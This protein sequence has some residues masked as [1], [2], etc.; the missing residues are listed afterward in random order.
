[1]VDV[2]IQAAI[3]EDFGFLEESTIETFCT[4]AMV[5]GSE[6]VIRIGIGFVSTQCILE[7][8]NC[9]GVVSRLE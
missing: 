9:S 4:H 7:S 5:D 3:V 8:L 1:M 6:I 2:E